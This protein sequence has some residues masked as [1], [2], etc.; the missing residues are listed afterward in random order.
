VPWSPV[1]R[2]TYGV[3]LISF[4]FLVGLLVPA[5]PSFFDHLG[6]CTKP[7]RV[8]PLL[9][10]P[11]TSRVPI[12]PRGFAPSSPSNLR[13]MG[14]PPFLLFGLACSGCGPA[15]PLFPFDPPGRP[16]FCVIH[17]YHPWSFF[18]P[19]LFPGKFILVPP[20]SSSFLVSSSPFSFFFFAT[21]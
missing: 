13:G 1:F 5:L 15:P 19:P 12:A 8:S 18:P 21:R 14:L 11:P 10:R 3:L 7:V 2:S 20:K 16:P 4:F 17:S 9:F 6:P